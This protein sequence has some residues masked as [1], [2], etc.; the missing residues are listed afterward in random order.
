[1]NPPFSLNSH[2][3]RGFLATLALL[4]G[5]SCAEA[6]PVIRLEKPANTVYANGATVNLPSPI[7]NIGRFTFTIRNTGD[8]ALTDLAVS[9]SGAN[10]AEYSV[11]T[12]PGASVA[13]AGTTTFVIQFTPG[14]AG[15]RPAVMTIASNDPVTPV[16]AVNVAGNGITSL[17]PLPNLNATTPAFTAFGFDATGLTFG[18]L[19]AGFTVTTIFGGAGIGKLIDN[20]DSTPL[21]GSFSDLLEDFYVVKTPAG[22]AYQVQSGGD[23]NDLIL[24][25]ITSAADDDGFVP[26]LN[27]APGSLAFQTDGKLVVGG[28]FNTV[29]G[30]TRNRIA[31][32]NIDGT[33]DASFNPGANAS[34]N[35]LAILD[36][37]KI[38][39]GGDMSVLGGLAR[40]GLVLLNQDGSADAFFNAGFPSANIKEIFIQPDGKILLIGSF[41]ID[42]ATS[43]QIARLNPNGSLDATFQTAG[44]GWTI[45]AAALQPDGK[46]VVVGKAS[47][48][49]KIGRLNAN[50]SLDASFSAT[51]D[52]EVRCVTVQTDG[53]IV[54][55]G[56]FKTVNTTARGW[57]ARLN[58]D[59]SVDP[60]YHPG[61]NLPPNVPPNGTYPGR[62][63]GV[64]TMALQADGKILFGGDFTYSPYT[65]MGGLLRFNADGGSDMV[66]SN[67]LTDRTLM[68]VVLRPD[69]KIVGGGAI[70]NFIKQSFNTTLASETLT[71][72]SR[73]RIQWLRG[74]TAPETFDVKF[75]LS[76]NGGATWT[77]LGAG[78]RISGGWELAGLNLPAQGRVRALARIQASQYSY[79]SFSSSYLAQRTVSFDFSPPVLSVEYPAGTPLANI[80]FTDNGPSLDLG[81]LNLHQAATFTFILRNTGTTPMTGIHDWG[82]LE[83]PITYGATTLAP[84][85]STTATLDLTFPEWNQPGLFHT[86]FGIFCN[87]LSGDFQV[88]FRVVFL[89]TAATWRQRYFGSPLNSGTGANGYVYAG[90]GVSNLLKF[91]SGQV[92]T[93]PGTLPGVM[94][95]DALNNLTFTYPRAKA[96]VASGATFVVEWSET[97]APGSWSSTGVT[98]EVISDDVLIQQVRATIPAGTGA[99]RFV[100]LRVIASAE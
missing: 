34:V 85:E 69:G 84:G 60:A 36:D 79:N 62:A 98:E 91:A 100:R 23:G 28:I 35:A 57:F 97:L 15:A 58:T 29:N 33:L 96:A 89:D 67:W 95:L 18:P 72:E 40:N 20:A 83:A 46:I 81:V 86:F 80:P 74:G 70:V 2:P 26:V 54:V 32:F 43:V 64:C 49:G 47:S 38:L 52:Y 5:F 17:N 30:T 94:D 68:S 1:M 42:A 27:E 39:V 48:T 8:A 3:F 99:K 90:D 65:G 16:Y 6:A 24:R 59:G 56:S 4:A 51:T 73:S 7:N 66:F 9:F 93:Q 12:A 41:K 78:V 25:K 21:S 45:L 44:P 63:T 75:Q 13:A 71:V 88:P 37:G 55:G 31:R 14:A 77:S 22:V 82:F 53:K 19:P 10:A 61:P 92:P 50:G 11:V 87:E 76:T